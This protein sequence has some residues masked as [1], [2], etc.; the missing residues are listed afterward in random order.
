MLGQALGETS[1]KSFHSPPLAHSPTLL[2]RY[3][4]TR[5]GVFATAIFKGQNNY[6]CALVSGVVGSGGG[7]K[8]WGNDRELKYGLPDIKYSPVDVGLGSGA[9]SCECG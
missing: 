2:L 3:A 5:A 4:V 8:C 1:P 9:S 6:M 7:V